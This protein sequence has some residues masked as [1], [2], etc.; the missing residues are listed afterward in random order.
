MTDVHDFGINRKTRPYPLL[1]YQTNIL[2]ACQFQVH[3]GW[4]PP[5]KEDVL[6]N[7]AQEDEGKTPLVYMPNFTKAEHDY[8]G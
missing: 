3:M 2:W 4:H 5:P 6:Q 8:K 1:W 7:K